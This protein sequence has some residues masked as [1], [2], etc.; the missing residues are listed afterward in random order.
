M[1]P[2]NEACSLRM[3]WAF[4]ASFQNSGLEVNWLSSSIRFCFPSTSKTPPQKFEA[5]L[6]LGKLLFGLF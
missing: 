2:L 5:L 4:S 3:P 6:Q 1:I